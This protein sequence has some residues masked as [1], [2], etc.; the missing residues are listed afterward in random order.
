M[1]R[2]D[3]LCGKELRAAL[4]NP[5]IG[6]KILVV[7]KTSSTNDLVWKMAQ[8][9]TSEGLV[10]FAESQSAG[11]GQRGNCWESAAGLGL[12]FSIFLRPKIGPPDSARIVMWTVH[13]VARVIGEESGIGPEIKSPNDIYLEGKKVAGV[14]VEMRVEKDGGYA[15]IVGIGVNVNQTDRDF[16]DEVRP[17]AGSLAMAAGRQIDRPALAAALLRNLDRSYREVFAV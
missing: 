13:T 7:E 16:S 8:D 10:V 5:C 3:S 4:T 1:S 15:A 6:H 17:R 2:G 9:G 14:L 11:R 12:W